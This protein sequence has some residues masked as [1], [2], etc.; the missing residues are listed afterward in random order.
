MASMQRIRELEANIRLHVGSA[1]RSLEKLRK[2]YA[3]LTTDERKLVEAIPLEEP[4]NPI[5]PY[6]G[7][8][9]KAN[10]P[11]FRW[12]LID[13]EEESQ[14]LVLEIECPTFMRGPLRL[15]FSGEFQGASY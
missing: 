15:Y 2:E 4:E 13:R 8:A 11:Y 3:S 14:N 5:P 1:Y 12:V 6:H 7:D 10:S 9:E